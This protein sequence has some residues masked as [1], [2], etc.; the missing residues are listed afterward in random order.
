MSTDGLDVSEHERRARVDHVRRA[1]AGVDAIAERQE[2]GVGV[3]DLDALGVDVADDRT[4]RADAQ[5]ANAK[6]PEP[7]PDVDHQR[8]RAAFEPAL[9]R[10]AASAVD[11]CCPVPNARLDPSEARRRPA[12]EPAPSTTAR[13]GCAGRAH[14]LPVRL[15]RVG[16]SRRRPPTRAARRR[17]VVERLARRS[18]VGEARDERHA[19]RAALL[20]RARVALLDAVRAEQQEPSIDPVGVLGAAL[21]VHL[22]K[23]RLGHFEI[24]FSFRQTLMLSVAG[25]LPEA[26][27]DADHDARDRAGD[28]HPAADPHPPRNPTGLGHSDAQRRKRVAARLHGDAGAVDGLEV[29]LDERRSHHVARQR[30]GVAAGGSTR[31]SMRRKMPELL[32]RYASTRRE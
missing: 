13:P 5:A 23:T 21:D 27:T 8:Q 29:V 6:M 25:W 31:A 22:S 16:P 9:E 17:R 20:Q 14:G 15:P 19:L 32:W 11:A 12:R 7:Q 4:R 28:E 2:R 24:V 18:F 26:L 30:D 3:G 1:H 10:G